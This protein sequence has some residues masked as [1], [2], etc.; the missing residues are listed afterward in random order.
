[1]H[2]LC[3]LATTMCTI[4]VSRMWD[5]RFVVCTHMWLVKAEPLTWSC[6]AL[7]ICI[8]PILAPYITAHIDGC[9]EG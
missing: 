4:H 8:D 6:V 1:M 7:M 5:N 9:V 2:V 3:H